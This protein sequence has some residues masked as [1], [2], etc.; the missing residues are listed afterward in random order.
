MKILV[1]GISGRT[2]KLVAAEAIRRGHSVVGIARDRS[3]VNVE[4]TEIVIGTPY[5]SRTVE[6]AISGCD[7]V[8]STL[9]A[10]PASQGLFSKI[11]SP[12]DFMSVSINNVI[13]AAENGGVKRVILMTALG[14][15]DSYSEIPAFFKFFMKIT[16]IRY[17][18]VDHDRQEK[19]L[20]NSKLDWTVVRPVM[21]TDKD[22]QMEVITNL[23]GT[24]KLNSGVSRSAVAHFILDC[25]E[26]GSFI[27]QKPGVSNK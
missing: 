25:A 8:V 23:K 5:D 12:L 2:G 10:F 19:M 21:L 26:K 14:V 27:R 17:A 4:G 20:E 3:K 9:S 11:K 15:G 7:A 22:D 6:K 18:Y 16:N 13:K 1:L 24:P